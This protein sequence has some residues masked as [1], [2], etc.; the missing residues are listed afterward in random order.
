MTAA[1]AALIFYLSSQTFAVGFTEWLLR[2]LLHLIR[3]QVSQE[4]FDT[5]HHLMRKS[6][7]VTEYAIFSTF[8]YHSL[9]ADGSFR[10]RWRVGLESLILAVGYSLTDEFH[11]IF[12]PG[13]TASLVDS[14]IDST[15]AALALALIYVAHRLNRNK[16]GP[17]NLGEQE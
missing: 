10:W 11:Q 4:T 13:R 12:V 15:G 3:I 14:G 6:A 7:H 8:I 5:L 9:S 17:E 16:Q 1:W 2:E